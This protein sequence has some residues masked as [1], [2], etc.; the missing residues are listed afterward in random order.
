MPGSRLFCPDEDATR[1]VGVRLLTIDRPGYGRSDPRPDSSLLGWADDYAQFVHLLD[2]PLCPIIGWSGGGPYA[3]A[4]AVR[5]PNLVTSVGLASSEMPRFEVPGGLDDVSPETRDLMDL[6][7]RD[8]PAA[9]EGI[10]RRCQ[11]FAD[12]PVGMIGQGVGPDDPDARLAAEPGMREVLEAGMREAGRQGSA[13]V[14]ADWIVFGE[15]WGFSVAEVTQEVHLWEGG[16]DAL[17]MPAW[18]E[19]VTR[20]IPRAT[21]TTYADDGHAALFP[22][23]A[24]MLSALA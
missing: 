20:T 7:G 16:A 9:I 17:A 21:L 22:H 15:P 1:A 6:L 10:T 19:Y 24:E 11:W 5:W 3:L 18:T 23:W 12:D 13:G 14:V 2:L 4:C 8:R